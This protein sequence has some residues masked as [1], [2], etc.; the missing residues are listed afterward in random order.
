M[1][2]RPR[3]ASDPVLMNSIMSNGLY[4]DP[5]PSSHHLAAENL[6]T[7]LEGSGLHQHTDVPSFEQQVAPLHAHSLHLQPHNQS[8]TQSMSSDVAQSTHLPGVGSA[9][10]RSRGSG[11]ESVG[12][13]FVVKPEESMDDILRFFLKVPFCYLACCVYVSVCSGRSLSSIETVWLLWSYAHHTWVC[14][15][16]VTVQDA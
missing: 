15:Q 2:G 14:Q 6:I 11:E 12:N 7:A 4:I 9:D 13:D 16:C 1:L 8:R 10:R 5:D 3:D